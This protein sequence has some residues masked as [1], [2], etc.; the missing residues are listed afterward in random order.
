[1]LGWVRLS[2][3]R[4]EIYILPHLHSKCATMKISKEMFKCHSCM[5]PFYPWTGHKFAR[6]KI[7]KMDIVQNSSAGIV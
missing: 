1:M 4:S 3:R 6:T 7:G 2:W 5:C